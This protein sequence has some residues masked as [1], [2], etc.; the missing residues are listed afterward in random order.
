VERET[1]DVRIALSELREASAWGSD[2]QGSDTQG[3]DAQGGMGPDLA[4]AFALVHN[5]ELRA[6]RRERRLA[7]SS[8]LSAGAW[9]NPEL[10]PNLQRLLSGEA[11]RL[12]MGVRLFPPAPGEE[13]AR[14]D[15]ARARERR[16]LAEIE[17]K[18][19]R[20]AALVRVGH[21]RL[22]LLA[23]TK[24]LLDASAKVQDGLI[25]LL[26]ARV[27]GRASTRLELVTARLERSDL[28][29]E[30]TRV[31]TDRA[32]ATARLA[33]LL[34]VAS[35]DR[36]L[37]AGPPCEPVVLAS[38]DALER[39]AQQRP[40]LRALQEAYEEGE[41][42]LLLERIALQPWPTFF[43]PGVSRLGD[44]PGVDLSAGIELPIDASPAAR[45]EA[46]R[47][48]LREEYLARLQEV[49]VEI[50]AARARFA[51]MVERRRYVAEVVL[52]LLVDAD[53]V[54]REGT[55]SGEVDPADLAALGDRVLKARR[56]AGEAAFECEETR[57]ALLVATGSVLDGWAGLKARAGAG[58]P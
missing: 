50:H 55:G 9:R 48:R 10:R 19:A 15:L 22:L 26:E 21:A 45:A 57:M 47:M 29:R 42:E 8:V 28:E 25:S 36:P 51:Q 3:S 13:D 7:E 5:R 34:G 52:P 24:R 31:E 38:D 49:R 17:H 39:V 56:A 1:L 44:G 54:L 43:E 2:T 27:A 23:D 33:S 6:L 41:Q 14:V 16:V 32:V 30:R 18:E 58:R 11:V 37:S 20:L 35:L 12:S 40:D 53:E 46:R 4:V